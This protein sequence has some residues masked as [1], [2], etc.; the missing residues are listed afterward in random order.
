MKIPVTTSWPAEWAIDISKSLKAIFTALS[1][2]F[3]EAGRAFRVTLSQHEKDLPNL[4]RLMVNNSWYPDFRIPLSMARALETYAKTNDISSIE[5]YLSAFYKASAARIEISLT[6][7]Y[8]HRTTVLSEAFNAYRNQQYILSIPVMLAQADGISEE[9]LK[10]HFFISKSSIPAAKEKLKP[11]FGSYTLILLGPLIELGTIRVHTNKLKGRTD[12]LNR[13][14][15]MHGSDTQYGTEKNA[16][17]C[18]SLLSYLN[19]V[20]KTIK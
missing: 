14:G 13:H 9:I 5:K 4:L 15:I 7:A 17:R 6:K 11:D 10:R 2:N 19:M 3:A 20:R 12:Y 1:T 18:I 16:L 8:P